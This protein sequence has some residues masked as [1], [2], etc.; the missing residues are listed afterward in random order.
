MIVSHDP[1]EGV[2]YVYLAGL[3][4]RS[5]RPQIID[6]KYGTVILDFDNEGNVIGVEVLG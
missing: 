5:A 3:G 4:E 1:G 6:G 2:A